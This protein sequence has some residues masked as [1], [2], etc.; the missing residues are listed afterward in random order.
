MRSFSIFA[1]FATA[2][3]AN[4]ASSKPT[5]NSNVADRV[6]VIA[7]TGAV[8]LTGYI[9]TWIALRL[10]LSNAREVEMYLPYMLHQQFVPP[11]GSICT[12]RFHTDIAEGFTSEGALYE[13]HHIDVVD[14]LSCDTGRF[15]VPTRPV[16]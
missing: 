2:L 16:R 7:H 10:R 11:S 8:P 5:E 4:S 12:V 6:L 15:V 13:L 3:A 14:E 1:A 9:R